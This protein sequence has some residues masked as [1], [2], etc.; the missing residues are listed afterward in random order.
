MKL[1]E[2]KINGV[3]GKIGDEEKIKGEQG[4]LEMKLKAKRALWRMEESKLKANIKFGDTVK[5]KCDLILEMNSK[6]L[7]KIWLIKYDA[8]KWQLTVK[9][10]L[11]VN[12]E[13]GVKRFK[14]NK[15]WS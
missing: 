9:P 11:E 6:L 7:M 8:K 4:K 10:Y 2:A 14:R 15:M 1:R 5:I 12:R 3:R 13:F